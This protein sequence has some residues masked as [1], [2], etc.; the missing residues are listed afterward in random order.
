[1][2]VLIFISLL[3]VALGNQVPSYISR[4]SA[5]VKRPISRSAPSFIPQPSPVVPR[6]E[7]HRPVIHRPSP[8]APRPSSEIHRPEIHRP[9]VPRPVAPRAQPTYVPMPTFARQT[10]NATFTPSPSPVA[11]PTANAFHSSYVKAQPW[12]AAIIVAFAALLLF[13]GFI[14]SSSKP[15]ITKTARPYSVPRPTLHLPT[16]NLR[17]RNVNNYGDNSPV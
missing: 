14:Y 6:P 9:E 3:G 17:F 10:I 15:K 11:G 2:N 8:V 5:A 13:M 1:M 12:I 4:P 7:I 16:E